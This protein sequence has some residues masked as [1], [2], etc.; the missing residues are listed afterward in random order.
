MQININQL[1]YWWIMWVASTTDSRF[2]HPL[3][4][5]QSTGIELEKPQSRLYD[6]EEVA[7]NI[8]T[9]TLYIKLVDMSICIETDIFGMGF[10]FIY[11]IFI[12]KKQVT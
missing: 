10:V 12:G 11:P 4:Q 8:L 5:M 9:Y 3:C 1:T 2:L 6:Y 7:R